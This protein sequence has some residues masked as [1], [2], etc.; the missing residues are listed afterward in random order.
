MKILY[1]SLAVA[2]L[3]FA[4]CQQGISQT[5]NPPSG[6]PAQ[7]W[8]DPKTWGGAVPDANTQVVIPLGKRIVLDTNAR[9]KNIT[10]LGAL[11]FLDKD[12]NLQADYIAVQGAMR[13]G[14][15]I[16][17]F[18]SKLS[19]TLSGDSAQDIMQMGSRGILV[20]GSLEIYAKPPTK[21]W[22][23][24]ADHVAAGANSLTLLENTTWNAGDRLVFAPTD[25]YNDGSFVKAPITELLELQSRNGSSVALKNAV[26]GARWGK[27]QYATNNGM[28]LTPGEITMPDTSKRNT[29]GSDVPT[30]LDARA[31]VGNLT[32]NV[33]IQAADDALWQQQK[34]GAHIMVM[35][36]GSKALLDGVELR[37]VGQAGRFGRYPV[38]F[39]NISY[40]PTGKELADADAVLKNSSIW[41]SAQRC[42]V[43][44]GSNGVKVQNNI[45]Y[46]IRGHAIFLEDAVERRNLLEG[47]LVL[48][49]RQPLRLASCPKG[50]CAL[51]IHERE[52]PSGF[53]IVN[54]DNTTRGN[55]VAD[56]EGHGY[57]LAFPKQVMGSNKNVSLN[58]IG[59]RPDNLPFGI[60]ES[61]VAHSI[62]SNGIHLDTVPIDSETGDLELNKYAPTE[63]GVPFNFQNGIRFRIARVTTY[64]TGSYWGGGGGIWNRNTKPDFL[65]WVSAD[66]QGGWFDGAGDDGLIAR[67]LIVAESLNKGVP[68]HS[69]QPLAALASYHSTFDMT[70]N[71][72]VGF[73]FVEDDK[74]SPSGVFKTGDYYITAVD[75]GLKRNPDNVLIQSHPGRRVQPF[76]EEHWTLAGA[77]W[78]AHGYW[79][80]AGN[81]WVYDQPFFTA[82]TNCVQVAPAGKNGVSCAGTYYAFGDYTTD[83]DNNR[84]AF[85]HPIEVTRVD[86]NGQ[87]IGTWSV[88]DGNT[89]P[90]LGNMRHFAALKDGRFVLRFPKRAG[91]GY[92]LPKSFGVTVRNV[93]SA[94]DS[95]LF[96][97]AFDGRLNPS[98]S[99]A[100]GAQTRA[101]DV[102]GANI[103]AVQADN[104][105]KTYYFDRAN[106]LIWL[107][108]LGGLKANPFWDQDPNSDDQLYHPM[109]LEIK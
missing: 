42:V 98:I 16:N 78:D 17:P 3:G 44:H 91:A 10:V 61:N 58:G 86:A 88:G 53:W 54:P 73:G 13:V 34:F 107:R 90:K 85:K 68:R 83:F 101:I 47:N 64:K 24:I 41:D 95:V 8:S 20:M 108:L 18:S 7:L 43:I 26:Q 82:G 94:S 50:D 35:G 14:S 27:L 63:G 51:L 59:A 12:L 96:A 75:K 25:F 31:E 57:W 28:S 65:E 71:I 105:G 29:G 109:R 45:C 76:T 66:H 49:V 100:T 79:G 55:A 106:N 32:R 11:E 102:A 89:A 62:G 60:F 33:V 22:T 40:A 93:L 77:L 97:V 37:R 48:K 19:I 56:I 99:L 15:A 87:A 6:A 1:S 46:D 67:S 104:S 103:A 69:K 21:T 2:A 4:A 38:H 9:V 74:N 5:V 72:V 52:N 23:K 36:A 70:Q 30:V 81:Y 80:P 84:Y 39:H 92:E